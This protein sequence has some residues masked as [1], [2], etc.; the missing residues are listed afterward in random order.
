MENKTRLTYITSGTFPTSK[1]SSIQ[2]MQMCAAF[3]EAGAMVK[4]IARQTA[5]D[6]DVFAYYGVAPT[7][8]FTTQSWWNIPRA[9]D[10]FQARSVFAE[11]GSNWVCYTRG[12]DLTAPMFALMR[13]ARAMIEVHG[14]PTTAR[15][16]WTLQQFS[17]HPRAHIISIS[18]PL[19]DHYEGEYGIKTFL[20]PDAVDIAR[21]TPQLT[22]EEARQQLGVGQV[23]N[24]PYIGVG[25]ISNLPI[26]VYV[27]GLYEGRG[28]E[29]LF[30]AVASLPVQVLI[31]GGRNDDDVKMWRDRA[32]AAGAMNVTF[33]GYQPPTRVPL[34]LFSADVL[35][36]PYN[37]RILTGSGE[38]I[39]KWTSPLKLYEYLA[40][41]RPIV[42]SDVIP[43]RSV[44]T[45]E[46][47]ALLTQ[48][49]NADSLRAAIQRL[50]DEK[51][52]GA[53]L[54][55]S[56]R[57]MAEA[58]TWAARAKKILELASA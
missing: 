30:K 23:G 29:I 54:A 46:D 40:A 24:L 53:N 37:S 50:I 2:V 52:L 9:A 55:A 18:Q 51:G 47:N 25:Q 36:M 11:R 22:K 8:T 58:N 1:A 39:T 5:T 45:H 19:S 44:L 28:L 57:K 15:E 16:R 38:D 35:V 32:A 49:D 21:F 33:A 48:P 34:Y 41:G 7:F 31:V 27:G 43:M 13:R 20:A 26:I 17:K 6:A 3:A 56:A 12:R 14:L 10:V 4:L 42:A